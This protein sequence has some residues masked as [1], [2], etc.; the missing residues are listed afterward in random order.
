VPDTANWLFWT[1]FVAAAG[2]WIYL[3]HRFRPRCERRG[4]PVSIDRLASLGCKRCI[5]E[6][7]GKYW[8]ERRL[9]QSAERKQAVRDVLSDDD[10]MAQFCERL[11]QF[12]KGTAAAAEKELDAAAR[13][14][15]APG[16]VG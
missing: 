15:R 11:K 8:T 16:Q 5:E 4:E 12:C 3:S 13:E 6:D 1:L 10:L 2:A 9:A 14:G 7:A